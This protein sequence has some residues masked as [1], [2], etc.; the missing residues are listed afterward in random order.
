MDKEHEYVD[1]FY[2]KHEGRIALG[3]G[4]NQNMS[5]IFPFVYE[6][7]D[8]QSTGVVALGV[9]ANGKRVVH[10]YHLGVF[11]SNIG[12]G[13][14]ILQELCQQAD[15]FDII[16]TVSAIIMPNGTDSQMTDDKLGGWYEQFGFKGEGKLFRQPL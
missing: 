5:E 15:R 12:N 10:I 13:S 4:Y 6:N 8:G 9:I 7:T 1:Y 11:V 14:I 16:L 3:V 2:Q